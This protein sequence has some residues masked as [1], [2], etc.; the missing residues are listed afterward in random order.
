[1]HRVS[2]LHRVDF[3]IIS[4]LQECDLSFFIVCYKKAYT[5]AKMK[6]ETGNFMQSNSSINFHGICFIIKIR[7]RQDISLFLKG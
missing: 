2:F 1:M 7:K 3:R 6:K 4:F 5:P